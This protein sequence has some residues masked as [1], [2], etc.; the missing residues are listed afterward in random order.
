MIKLSPSSPQPERAQVFAMTEEGYMS[1]AYDMGTT[2][3][4]V[5]ICTHPN[6]YSHV[7][8]HIQPQGSHMASDFTDWQSTVYCTLATTLTSP[9]CWLSLGYGCV[10]A[11][12]TRPPRAIREHF[13]NHPIHDREIKQTWDGHMDCEIGHPWG[14]LGLHWCRVET[15]CEQQEA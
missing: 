6:F 15:R 13:E 11:S 5:S 9:W 7:R 4:S 12:V 14:A 1:P 2:S 8:P 3:Q 10:E